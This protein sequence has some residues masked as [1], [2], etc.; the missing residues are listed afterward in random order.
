MQAH[1]ISKFQQ[2]L[3]AKMVQRI[4]PP[5]VPVPRI[6]AS[7]GWVYTDARPKGTEYL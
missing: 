4:R 7:A 1:M 2:I 5:M 3:Q 6:K